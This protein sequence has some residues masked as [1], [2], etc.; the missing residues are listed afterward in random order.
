[1]ELEL[2]R[3]FVKVIQQGSFTR[4]ANILKIPKSTLSKNIRRLEDETGT[5]LIIRTTRSLTLTAAGRAFFESCVGPVQSLEDARKSLSGADSVM[6]GLV[7]ITAPE[8]LGGYAVAPVVAEL[9]R[10]NQGL[11]FEL[12]YTD[13]IVDLVRD[14]FDLAVRIGRLPPSNFKVIKLGE[15]SLIPVAAKSYLSRFPKIAK[16]KDL[17][18]HCALSFS[19]SRL[20]DAWTLKRNG[21]TQTVKL[22]TRVSSNQM[23]SLLK[24]SVAGGGVALVPSYLAAEDLREGRL[25]RVL[26]DWA[27]PGMAVSLVSPLATTSSARLKITADHLTE[28]LRRLLREEAN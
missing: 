24:M 25:V 18:A 15:V 22:N 4:A 27:A 23:T 20:R 8:D 6:Q 5:K 14:G 21:D 9:S 2:T 19:E 3:L 10:K 28:R 17:S 1:M 12:L 7:R 11:Q 16:P 13:T 26:P